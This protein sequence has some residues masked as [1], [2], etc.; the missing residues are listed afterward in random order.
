[1]D[2]G[3]LLDISE[4]R[5]FHKTA[6]IFN[7]RRYTYGQVKNRVQRLM[8]GLARLDVRKGDRVSTLMWNSAEMMEINLAAVRLGAVFTPLNYR[9]KVPELAYVVENARPKVLI[10]DDTCQDLAGNMASSMDRAGSLISTADKPGSGFQS[11]EALVTDNEPF[12]GSAEVRPQDRCQLLYTSGTTARPKGV[13]LSHENVIWNAFNMIHARHDRP[14]DVSLIVGPLFHAAAL[15]SHYIPRLA[16]G[17]TM[18][19]MDRFDPERMMDLIEREG[20]TIVPGNPSLFIM[21]LEY[22]SSKHHN[23]STVT[24]LTSGADKLTEQTKKALMDLFPQAEGVYDIYGLTEAGP[25]VTLL[26]AAD[27]LRKSACVGLP[28]PFMQVRLLDE[29]GEPVPVGQP[30]E[31]VVRGPSVMEG[32]YGLPEETAEVLKE[33]WL[34]T[35]DMARADEEGF[36]YIVDRK[37]DMIVS[38]GENVSAREVEEALFSHASVLKA[39]VFSLPDAKWGEK[40]AAAVILREGRKES[41]EELRAFLRERLAGYKAPKKIFFTD[42]FPESG[43]G[44]VQKN[45]LK[46]LYIDD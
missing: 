34:F 32:Y 43:T 36:L 4:A 28:L 37:K 1:M 10:S 40:V 23:T 38:G 42:A 6:I 3:R 27:S 7:D 14:D 8:T 26:D 9:L 39:A 13:V 31:L 12:E 18:I 24:T 25:C 29:A 21:L 19:I 2:V 15:N 11:Y 46:K 5:F 30:G 41:E 22:C 35:G 33:G 17:A 44:K 20:A 45:V 16:L